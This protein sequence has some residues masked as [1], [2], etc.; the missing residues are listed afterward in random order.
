MAA[1]YLQR[2]PLNLIKLDRRFI[3]RIGTETDDAIVRAVVA[4]LN[5]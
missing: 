3:A 2:L 4:R 1:A 5:V